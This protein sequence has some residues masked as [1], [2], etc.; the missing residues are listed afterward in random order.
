MT[1]DE[2]QQIVAIWGKHLEF[3]GDRLAAL[4]AG[5]I[6]RSLLPLPVERL[7]EALNKVAKRYHDLGDYDASNLVRGSFEHLALYGD[8][9]N[10]LSAAAMKFGIP[11]VRATVASRLLELQ[12]AAKGMA[13]KP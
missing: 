11:E 10:A 1:L 9:D 5:S 6:P 4:F 7:E 2:A 12:R 13:Y 8:D 3:C